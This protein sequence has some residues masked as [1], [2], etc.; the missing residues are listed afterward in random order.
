M[1]KT[2]TADLKPAPAID[3]RAR[4]AITAAPVHGPAVAALA[5]EFGI[6][7]PAAVTKATEIVAVIRARAHNAVTVMA[8]APLTIDDLSAD[9]WADRVRAHETARHALV[10]AEHQIT[11]VLHDATCDLA[12]ACR[13]AL[14]GMVDQLEA[15]FVQHYDTIA[16]AERA[17]AARDDAPAAGEHEA[18]QRFR[19][20]HRAVMLAGSGGSGANQP[21]DYRARWWVT[22]TWTRATWT[23][24]ENATGPMLGCPDGGELL[25]ALQCGASVRLARTLAQ[26][27]DEFVG[28]EEGKP[29]PKAAVSDKDRAGQQDWA[30]IGEYLREQKVS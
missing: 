17:H 24:L 11:G 14:P 1:S 26:P 13:A 23:T 8:P 2:T 5:V 16:R 21:S 3:D 6:P 29:V 22:H 4:D 18:A 9:D 30:A 27:W 28:F 12:A 7:V 19:R 15:W 25:V 20:V 10:G